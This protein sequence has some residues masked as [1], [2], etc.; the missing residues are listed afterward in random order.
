V[1][2]EAAADGWRR[3]L[4]DALAGDDG[5]A[6]LRLASTDEATRLLPWT[7]GAVGFT[8]LSAGTPGPAEALLRQAQ[9]R[10]PDDFW[11]NTSLAELLW[12]SKY[13]PGGA[14][15]AQEGMS[16]FRVCV[17][18]RP[19]SAGAHHN[20]GVALKDQGRLEEAIAA[21]QQALRLNKDFAAAHYNLGNALRAK[22]QLDEGIAEY[23]QALQRNKDFAPAHNNLGTALK[24]KGMLEEAIAEYREALRINKD[25]ALA[26]T[27]LGNAL[28]DKDRLEEAIAKYHEALRIKK[29][30]AAAHYNLG[31]ALKDQG[32]L[33]EAIAAYQEAV[34]L[35][36]D[37]ALVRNSLGMALH[38][39]GRLD[40][41]MAAYREA[42]RIKKDY[43]EAHSNLGAALFNK[44]RPE[45]AIAEFKE[46][47]RLDTDYAEAHYNL[48]IALGD[49]GRREEAIAE[50]KAALRI[51]MDYAEAH[52]SLGHALR[53]KG[54]F[55]EA[56][57]HFRLGHQLGSK[58]PHWPHP[59]AQW[60]RQ[61][62]R[63]AELD[64]RL[65]QFLAGQSQPADTAERLALAQL[66]QMYK[67]L[68]AAAAR[69]YAEA[70]ARQPAAAED[71]AAG[72]RYN[73]ACAAARA[74]CGQGKDAAT[75]DD[76]ER[77]RLRRQALDWLTSELRV[78]QRLLQEQPGKAGPVVAQKMR[79]WSQDPDFDGVRGAA[80]TRLTEAERQGWQ[81][82]WADVERTLEQ[83]RGKQTPRQNRSEQP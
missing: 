40:E 64:D 5:R 31:N 41:A 21:Y 68:F 14:S 75:L 35:N 20:L 46:A 24:A 71:L 83:A 12:E 56:L 74:G 53:D 1:A 3:Q 70:F 49:K 62:Q 80:L 11:I 81:Q 55:A 78:W 58:R 19:Q 72:H 54:Q 61:A 17:A 57:T 39:R 43:P 25:Y 44:G 22:G 33:D 59:S 73:A 79:H 82:L 47:L 18:L 6:V 28:R 4:R 65:P 36:K 16:F 42:F 7:W 66:C 63:L 60:L 69:F 51:K 45:E 29:D 37:D 9:Q 10:H 52:C 8:L 48:G 34:R 32:R 15:R 67:Q 38:A 77:G 76:K 23:K 26:H 27:N 30:D 50:F 13:A 2:R